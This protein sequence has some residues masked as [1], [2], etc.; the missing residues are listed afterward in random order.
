MGVA[1]VHAGETGSDAVHRGEVEE[2]GELPAFAYPDQ[3]HAEESEEHAGGKEPRRERRAPRDSPPQQQEEAE[4]PGEALAHPQGVVVAEI[5]G[6]GVGIE[7]REGKEAQQ[8]G[9][10]GGRREQGGE[11]GHGARQ[12]GPR[13]RIG[14]VQEGGPQGDQQKEVALV[15]EEPP[16]PG[17]QVQH[18][19]QGRDRHQPGVAEADE[20]DQVQQQGRPEG[21]LEAGE[22]PPAPSREGNESKGWE[23][24]QGVGSR[25]G[26]GRQSG[27][28]FC[29]RCGG[30]RRWRS[31]GGWGRGGP[32][33]CRQRRTDAG[34]LADPHADPNAN[35]GEQDLQHAHDPKPWE[36]GPA[37]QKEGDDPRG[38]PAPWAVAQAPDGEHEP[39]W[40]PNHCAF[41]QD[42]DLLGYPPDQIE[43]RGGCE[44]RG[45]G[46]ARGEGGQRYGQG[47]GQRQAAKQAAIP[48]GG[49]APPE[50]GSHQHPGGETEDQAR[51]PQSEQVGRPRQVEALLIAHQHRGPQRH[52]AE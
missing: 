51:E 32:F 31:G 48:G 46:I 45:Q 13:L 8:Q 2:V 26:E 16:R 20:H 50:Q 24:G 35:R 23:Q 1:G 10:Q 43:G 17:R 7:R 18:R 39:Q 15:E 40:D 30:G 4:P 44:G 19:Q 21:D 3:D 14:E 28:G 37:N 33:R 42:I 22:S 52:K 47:A 38:H 11:R 5:G 34:A 6:E 36:E 27:P 9:D 25:Q 12:E 29:L 41:D 49:C